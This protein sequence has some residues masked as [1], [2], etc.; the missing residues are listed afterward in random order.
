ME[1]KLKFKNK[2]WIKQ[3]N[4]LGFIL[5]ITASTIS[6]GI[7][8]KNYEIYQLSSQVLL[9]S[10][11]TWIVGIFG[12]TCLVIATLDLIITKKGKSGILEWTKSFSNKW[13]HQS[14]VNYIKFLY[15]PI[16]SFALSIYAVKV[17]QL[18]GWT[19][20]SGWGV[21]FVAFFIFFIFNFLSLVG[22]YA[23]I[24]VQ[25]IIGAI[26]LIG[27]IVIPILTLVNE[28]NVSGNSTFYDIEPNKGLIALSPYLVLIAGIPAISFAFNGF[29]N[30]S[31]INNFELSNQKESKVLILALLVVV[32]TYL[33]I[34]IS[35]NVTHTNL[36][37]ING[38]K[39]QFF[40]DWNT[41]LKVS[42]FIIGIGIL[43]VI[44][45]FAMSVPRQIV[46]L[47]KNNQA[48]EVLWF[49]IFVFRKSYDHVCPKQILFSAW[50][51]YFIISSF[52]YIIFGP[53]GAFVYQ[54]SSNLAKQ[55]GI[56]SA[57]IYG[58]VD[59]LTTYSSIIFFVII[60]VATLGYLKQKIKQKL[61]S[62]IKGFSFFAIIGSVIIFSGFVFS[63]INIIV[64]VTGFN[65]ASVADFVVKL[66]LYLV[67]IVV[68][69]F[70]PTI[71]YF[72]TKFWHKPDL[73]RIISPQ[74][75]GYQICN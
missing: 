64:N 48:N 19:L 67:L 7:F 71:N 28:F 56:Y 61:P 49:Q 2:K 4:Y 6:S 21:V 65:Q 1:L 50:C 3:I 57:R 40:N 16:N 30:A 51:S 70:V 33:F 59:F 58:L 73:I 9:L 53:I 31:T 20:P 42:N 55:F 60:A 35:F 75:K 43:G 12:L 24:Q 32:A 5:F 15:N 39:V 34:A 14:A 62:V 68:P 52:F 37:A 22:Y 45:G 46:A 10:I 44:N 11:I 38:T 18:S 13:F 17:F 47:A 72:A 41:I 66:L 25:K 27:V 8:L 54:D 26:K 23:A 36:G 29:Y 69:I 74:E 63:I